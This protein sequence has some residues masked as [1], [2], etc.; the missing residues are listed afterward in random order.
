MGKASH[1]QETLPRRSRAREWVAAAVCLVV[2]VV[3]AAGPAWGEASTAMDRSSAPAVSAA[4]AEGDVSCPGD[5][6]GV[7]LSLDQEF[8]GTPR[9]LA[10]DEGVLV[11]YTL[12]CPYERADGR[13]VAD[14]TLSWSRYDAEDLNCETLELTSE[15]AGDG[16]IQG[17][18]DHPSLSARVTYGAASEEVLPAVEDGA[19]EL[20][21]RVPE[22][23]A[24]CAGGASA[25]VDA[26]I[27]VPEA[28]S[29]SGVP[30][31]LAVVLLG[32][33]ALV[34][35]VVGLLLR[36]GKQRR[37]RAAAA[38]ASDPGVS[39]L[40]AALRAQRAG[41][42]AVVE[43][44]AMPAGAAAA[45]S[46][47]PVPSGPPP[48]PG[49]GAPGTPAGA[50]ERRHAAEVLR[51]AEGRRLAL[52]ARLGVARADLATHRAHA[53]AVRRLVASVVAEREHPEYLASFAGLMALAGAATNLVSTSAR[54]A[55]S[56]VDDDTVG[57]RA[58]ALDALHLDVI[59][60]A[61]SGLDDSRFWLWQD[62]RLAVVEALTVLERIAPRLVS[63]QIRLSRQVADLG[64]ALEMARHDAEWARATLGAL[65]PPAPDLSATPTPDPQPPGP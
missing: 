23:A 46:T 3:L 36:R 15:P 28:S 14:L 27:A 59:A 42:P 18:L 52:E 50:D 34:V 43:D 11:R 16:R 25:G 64:R 39:Q 33:T 2:P 17:A 63:V 56:L 44:A 10:N 12:L 20:L 40:A 47:P 58:L 6:D 51:L 41:G 37:Q 38:A 60:A 29:S 65:G 32:G 26:S 24:P 31:A 21:T 19:A 45:V 57:D 55:A 7:P 35:L 53:D 49:P 13:A 5:L 48:D 62:R 54:R 1:V 30:I 9:A 61:E 8:A 4:S 22:D